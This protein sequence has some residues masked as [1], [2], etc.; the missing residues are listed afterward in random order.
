MFDRQICCGLQ[1]MDIEP[2]FKMLHADL[3]NETG[4]EI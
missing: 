4:K 1:M 2:V 3:L